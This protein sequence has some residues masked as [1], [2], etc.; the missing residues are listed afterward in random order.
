MNSALIGCTGFV[1]ST[2]L[3]SQ[4]FDDGYNSS[5]IGDIAGKSYDLV[6]CAGAPAAKWIANKDPEGDAAAIAK[7]TG[8]LETVTAREFVLISTIDV[9][10][11]P[12]SGADEG[13]VIDASAN[14]TYGRNRY[15]LEEF[16]RARFPHARIVRLPAL[17]GEGLKKNAVFDLLNGNAVDAINPLGEFQWY[18]MRRLADDLARIGASDV[19]LVNLFPERVSMAAIIDAFFPGAAVGEPKEP[20]PRYDLRTL[21]ADLFD[22]TGTTM[23]NATQVLGELAR[24]VADERRRQAS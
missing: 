24:Y 2:L 10:P 16:V 22:H 23:M 13:A 17:F 6:V 1:G 9:Y 21:H 19:D 5:N 18:P 20:A 8:P 3:R 4:D 7:L 15:A 11:D 12:M 14:H